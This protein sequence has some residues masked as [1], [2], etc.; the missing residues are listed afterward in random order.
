MSTR[1]VA[2]VGAGLSGSVL[3][4]ELADSGR[5]QVAVFEERPHVGG[6]CRCFRDPDSGVLV[7]EF[8]PHVFHTSREDVWRYVRRWDEF[9]PHTLRVKAVTERGVFSLPINLLTINQF[10]GLRLDPRRAEAFIAGLGD[11]SVKEPRTF[12][13]QALRYLGREL[14]QA[15]FRGYT[16]KQ[17]G[18]EPAGLPTS[19][20]ARLPVRFNYDDG[21]YNDTYSAIP[22]HGYTH[23]VEQL[24]DHPR[25]EVHLS[26]SIGRSDAREFDHV[27]YTGSL[28]RW[29]EYDIGRLAYRS[30]LFER[31]IERGDYQGT[32]VINYCEERVPYTRVTEF[33][34]FTPWEEHELTVC[35]RETSIP[36]GAGDPLC[37]PVPLS[38][39]SGPL[40]EYVARAQ[41]ER[42]ATFLGRL[43]TYRYLDMHV[44][45]AEALDLAR[46]VLEAPT[47]AERWPRFT[48]MPVPLD[49]ISC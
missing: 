25:L 13:E 26:R 47:A 49:G 44:V 17:W 8:G 27:F 12:E 6:N 11:R 36:A 22:V 16:K 37:Y 10:F 33:K 32:A 9:R 31:L 7:H 30:V 29:F 39:R 21:Y 23:V 45:V 19:I 28:D 43:G 15:F 34:H 20:L 41:R 35:F 38:E 46:K 40:W 4:R 24:L 14:Y 1:K 48:G 2:V 18:I 5:F 42:H 3:A